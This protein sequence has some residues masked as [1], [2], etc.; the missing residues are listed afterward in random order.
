MHPDIPSLLYATALAL[1]LGA[2]ACACVGWWRAHVRACA[3]EARRAVAEAAHS[4]L[5]RAVFAGQAPIT[6]SRVRRVQLHPGLV[7]DGVDVHSADTMVFP[8]ER[9]PQG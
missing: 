8:S 6:D 5:C 7:V 4:D 1:A 2:L 3:A 9:H